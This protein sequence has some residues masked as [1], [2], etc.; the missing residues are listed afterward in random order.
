MNA[1][2]YD[3]GS[4]PALYKELEDFEKKMEA[5]GA[6]ARRQVPS[7]P[8][9]FLWPAFLTAYSVIGGAIKNYTGILNL[10]L[11]LTPSSRDI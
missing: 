1:F 11:S 4:N 10:F 7:V 2:W 8:L 9:R 6:D 3:F 5:M